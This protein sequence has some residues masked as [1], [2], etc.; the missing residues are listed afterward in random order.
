M[1]KQ[2]YIIGLDLGI[3]SVGWACVKVAIH[4]DKNGKQQA[5]PIGLLDC[6]VRCFAAAEEPKTGESLNAARRAA[7]SQRR[8]IARRASR[9]REVRKLLF[10]HGLLT[11]NEFQAAYSQNTQDKTFF[12][13]RNKKLLKKIGISEQ[14]LLS[15]SLNG[16][17]GYQSDNE[18]AFFTNVWQLRVEA[19][20]RLLTRAEFVAVICHLIKH[21]GYLS[22][23]KS[24]R[25][26]AD[27][28][29]GK[30]LAGVSA[31]EKMIK[32]GEYQSPAEIAV[33]YFKKE[34]GQMR[35]KQTYAY[36]R[37]TKGENKGQFELDD[38]GQKIPIIKDGVHQKE[39]SYLHTINRLDLEN[40]LKLIF[41]RQKSFGNS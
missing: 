9:M 8:T 32:A 38:K 31:N 10:K 25:K 27:A 7:R 40:E 23:R 30:M 29:T 6:G 12:K 28:E 33:Y 13:E 35:N 11:K 34:H 3:A 26:N 20:N 18:K 4:T 14:Q 19:L 24:E 41:E 1:A 36:K 21:R 22:T 16:E 39:G 17:N 37:I 2:D 5:Q 15:G